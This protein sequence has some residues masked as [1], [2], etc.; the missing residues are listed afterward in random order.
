VENALVDPDAVKRLVEAFDIPRA[1]ARFLVA[2]AFKTP[3]AASEYLFAE[4]IRPHDP[5]LFNNMERAVETIQAAVAAKK[6]VM[7][8]GDY[9]VDGICGAALLYE[10]LSGLV[11]HVYRFV[12]DRRKDGYG[13]AERAVQWALDNDIGLVICVDC[14]TSDGE[15]IGRL[16]A[17]GIDVVICDHHE[18][19]VD[20]D[21][22]GIVLNPVHKDE[23]YPFKG[24]CGTG[25]AFKLAA[26]L[27]ARGVRGNTATDALLDLMALA[28]VGDL[29]PLVDENRRFV[30]AG[31]RLI[32]DNRRAGLR[33]LRRVAGLDDREITARH[34]GFVLAPRLNAPG[35]IANPK[36]A[37]AILCTNDPRE[38]ARL[39][40]MLEADNDRRKELTE[41]V[42]N[43][44]IDVIRAS[45]GW[46]D[47]G[48][49]VVAG[50]GWDEGVLGIAAARVVEE[51]GRPT[52]VMTRLDGKA[53]GSGR[54]V[55]GVHLKEQLD[56]VK[57]HLD[58]YGGHAQAVG[59]T[60]DA[61][62]I[63]A[64]IKDL[65][66]CLDIAMAPLPKQPTL[67]I[68]AELSVSDCSL[69]LI[70]FL[71]TCEPFGRGNR[72]P[73]W[74]ITN[75]TVQKD[76]RFVGNGHLKVFFEDKDGHQGNAIGFNWSHRGIDAEAIPGTCVDLAFT[77]KKGFFMEKYTPDLHLL[78]IRQSGGE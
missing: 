27:E 71:A 33:A 2:R 9:D 66:A 75:V 19:P 73:V 64:F 46:H 60:V 18:F 47:R 61:D 65:T 45:D 69:E 37:L 55:H 77:L 8:H 52:L 35:R 10:Y 12:P 54:S 68:D 26:A 6:R 32:G 40:G 78:D 5:F 15:A 17:A 58:R 70:D 44:V 20:R 62:K 23:A 31:L 14:G 28:T 1:G 63:D 34:I 22:R 56:K 38:T 53:K 51:F 49:F 50:E 74:K 57:S 30:R 39:A 24:L 29:S 13:V 67:R 4:D 11:P 7:V 42:T 76:T 16:E 59:C 72:T 25:V 3:E 36:P 48:G 41:S 21:V 43:Q